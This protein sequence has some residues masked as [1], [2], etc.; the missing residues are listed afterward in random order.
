MDPPA[1]RNRPLL[2]AR[3]VY[4]QRA[5]MQIS[6]SRQ[7]NDQNL[8]FLL[9]LR[10]YLSFFEMFYIR[11]ITERE[12]HLKMF[13]ALDE[14]YVRVVRAKMEAQIAASTNAS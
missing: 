10:E 13:Q 14:V 4:F 12:H 3:L 6:P 1:L 2:D 8:P 9:T 7:R 5:F 11:S